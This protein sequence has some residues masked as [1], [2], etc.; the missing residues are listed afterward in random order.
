M[1]KRTTLALFTAATSACSSPVDLELD[2]GGRVD[3]SRPSTGAALIGPPSWS[4]IDPGQ[5]QGYVHDL[6]WTE[7]G[8]LVATSLLAQEGELG[9]RKLARYEAD[10]AP[11]WVV[12]DGG[13]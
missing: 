11:S 3:D 5:G 13:F 2:V 9:V 1:M 12:Q 6:V 10:G 7:D 4:T 8:G